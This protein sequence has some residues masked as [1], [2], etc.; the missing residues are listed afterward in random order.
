MNAFDTPEIFRVPLHQV[1]LLTCIFLSSSSIVKLDMV[2]RF[3]SSAI[4]SPSQQQLQEA[5]N[6]LVAVGALRINKPGEL[7]LT[8]LGC[9]ISKLPMDVRMAKLLIFSSILRCVNPILTICA[10]LSFQSPMM[11]PIDNREA[12]KEMQKK[13]KRCKSD[14]ISYH[15]AYEAFLKAKASGK[16]YQFCKEHFLSVSTMYMIGKLRKQFIE[17]L[18]DIGFV[19]YNKRTNKM[20][21]ELANEQQFNMKVIQACLCAGLYPNVIKIQPPIKKYTKIAEGGTIEKSVKV[22]ELKFFTGERKR[23]FLHPSSFNFDES[24][25]ESVWLVY[26]KIMETSRVF[27]H[28]TTMVYPYPLLLFGSNNISIEHE[29]GYLIV[30]NV[31]PILIVLIPTG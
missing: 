19:S 17:L 11:S 29:K 22:R 26:L 3:L 20:S 24:G 18:A 27:V 9:H 21:D 8:P 14:H 6:Y 25:Y 16:A 31:I 13:F 30:R 1:Y 2:N 23:V 15:I 4:E 5:Q 7:Y 28:D 10:V 12:A